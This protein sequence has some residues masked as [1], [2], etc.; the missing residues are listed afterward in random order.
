MVKERENQTS[1][2]IISQE[3]AI[4]VPPFNPGTSAQNTGQL[5]SAPQS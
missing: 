3:H 5:I 4:N 1:T 2:E